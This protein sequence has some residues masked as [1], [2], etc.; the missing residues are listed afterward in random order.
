MDKCRTENPEMAAL[1]ELQEA[2]G[3][4][5]FRVGQQAAGDACSPQSVRGWPEFL[6]ASQLGA[7][8]RRDI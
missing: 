1:A 4:V 5:D 3:V 2:A 7:N 6:E 8:I